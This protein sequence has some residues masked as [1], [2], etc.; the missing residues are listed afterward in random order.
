M[1][2]RTSWSIKVMG[3]KQ[4]KMKMEY[5]HRRSGDFVE[6]KIK[7][8]TRRTVYRSKFNIS[9]KSAILQLLG[10]LEKYSGFSIYQL[11]QQKLKIGDWF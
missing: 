3:K 2:S 5:L 1:D 4:K 7:D 11:V 8:S 10:I 6:V 9:D